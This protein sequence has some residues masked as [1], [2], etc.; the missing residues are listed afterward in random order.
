MDRRTFVVGAAALGLTACGAA[1]PV[2]APPALLAARAYRH[3]GPP[4]LSLMTMKSTGN[5]QGEHTGLMISASQRVIFDPAGTFGSDVMAQNLTN[6]VP[7]HMDV[8]YGITPR[9]EDFYIRYHA[10][11]TY[12]VYRQ[13]IPVT[14]EQAEAALRA[15]A[16]YGAVP[17]AQCAIATAEVLRQVPGFGWIEPSLWP[18]RLVEQIARVP[19][20]TVRTYRENDS[21]DKTLAAQNFGA[22]LAQTG[23]TR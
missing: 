9:I 12:Y 20:V 10:R 8:H 4:M 5:N 17:K 14:P 3:P 19:G 11:E 22:T 18:D 16:S 7:E 6:L 15:A 2:S 13:D 23:L 1:E 21:D